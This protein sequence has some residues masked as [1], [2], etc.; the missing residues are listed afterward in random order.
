MIPRDTTIHDVAAWIRSGDPFT[1]T[2]YGNGEWDLILARGKHTGSR[3]QVFTESLRQAMRETVIQHGGKKMGVQSL[4]YLH[5]LRLLQPAEMWLRKHRVKIA[6][7][8]GNVLHWASQRGEL[9]PFVDALEDA[10][11]LFVG[12]EHIDRIPLD[13]DVMVIP[14]RNCWQ[15]VDSIEEAI[16]Q[17][18]Q[19]RTVCISAGPAA[20]VLIHRL[21]NE[22]MQLIDCGSLWD[23]YCGVV[24]RSY[25]KTIDHT[26][27]EANHIA[28]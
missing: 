19:N 28:A 11:T 4:R 8:S 24:S 13:G 7:E 14:S 15:Q 26:I 16:R 9:S 25:H 6:W 23:V 21:R 3:S 17:H 2:R 12:P 10:D 22:P 18:G 27:A 1:F 5:K 20:K